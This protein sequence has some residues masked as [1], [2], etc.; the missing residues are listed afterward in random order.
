M[1]AALVVAALLAASPAVADVTAKDAW[2]RGTV[3]GQ[4][5]SGAF[6]I[7]T[8][9]EDAKVVAVKSP[10]AKS[11]E[12]HMTESHHGMMHMHAVEALALPANKPVELKP[13]AHHV[14]LMGLTRT[15]GAGDTVPLTFIIEDAR[16]KRSSVEVNAAVR[17]LGQ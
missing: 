15:L 4:K 10:I 8:S 17:P 3:A 16:G 14:M 1:R 5:S 2:A 9:T 6:L 7:L 11:A 12:I 13:G